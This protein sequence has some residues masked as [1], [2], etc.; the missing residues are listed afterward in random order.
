MALKLIS[1][2]VLLFSFHRNQ[3]ENMECSPVQFLKQE[4]ATGTGC[5]AGKME[6]DF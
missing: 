1:G 5:L 2:Q 6:E 3:C 4:L